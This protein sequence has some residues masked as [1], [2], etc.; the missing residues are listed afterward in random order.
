[1]KIL[2]GILYDTYSDENGKE[3]PYEDKVIGVLK[4]NKVNIVT[5]PD[6]MNYEMSKKDFFEKVTDIQEIWCK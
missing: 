2:A 6:F 4:G 5:I 1:M 3:V